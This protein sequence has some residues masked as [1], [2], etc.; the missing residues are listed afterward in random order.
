[1]HTEI[2]YS[3]LKN[4]P[5]RLMPPHNPYDF[6]KSEIGKAFCQP[7]IHDELEILEATEGRVGVRAA[8]REFVLDKGESVLIKSRVPHQTYA[9]CGYSSHSAIQFLPDLLSETTIS[10]SGKYL[11]RFINS[12]DMHIFRSGS[13]ATAELHSYNT[14]IFNEYEKKLPSYELY[15]KANL[16]LMLGCFYRNGILNNTESFFNSHEIGKIMPLLKYIDENYAEPITLEQAGKLLNLNRDYFC[17]LFKK[18]TNMTFTDYLNYVRICHT[19]QPLTFSDKSIAE[20]SLDAGFSSVSY[21][22]RVFKKYKLITPS[23]YR[24]SKYADM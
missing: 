20:I 8:G 18:A 13:P 5:V 9:A 4:T 15:I 6:P 12:G 19:E 3:S 2:I 1:M 21:F 14:V 24:H 22:N 16:Q 7:H 10:H 11:S 17:R 23:E